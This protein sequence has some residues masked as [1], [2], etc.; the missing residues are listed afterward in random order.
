MLVQVNDT[1]AIPE[2]ELQFTFCTGSGPG[3]QNV[4]KV[5]T[6]ATLLFDLKGSRSLNEWQRQRVAEK[7]KS[8][9]NREGILRIVCGEHRTQ[10]ANRDTA[11]ER[12]AALLRDALAVDAPRFETRVPKA[13]KAR[14]L[15][16]KKRRGEVKKLRSHTVREWD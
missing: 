12:F 13:E 1:L 14:R 16:E 15:D 6:R 8:R 10:L 9:I 5:A 7:L 4:N 11:V 2:E 3:G